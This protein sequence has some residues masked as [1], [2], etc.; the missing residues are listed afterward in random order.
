MKKHIVSLC[1]GLCLIAPA[2]MM[3]LSGCAGDNYSRST[4]EYI[5]DKALVARVHGALGDNPE[6]K[7]DGVDVNVFRGV[8]Q[9]SGFVNTSDQKRQA[10]TIAQGVQ[11]VKSV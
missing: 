8:V 4:G 10:A 6:Y 5:D 11:G 1:F 7:F 9:L 3:L 2:G